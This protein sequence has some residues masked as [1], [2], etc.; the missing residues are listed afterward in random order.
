MHHLSTQLRENL[1]PILDGNQSTRH[2]NTIVNI[3]VSL[4]L[5][6]LERKRKGRQLTQSQGISET[7]L[8]Y[9]C[10]ADLF[11]RNDMGELV[12]I[13]AY[14][15]SVD[16]RAVDGDELLVQLRKLVYSRVNQAIFR[17]Y[18]DVDP[19]LSR[20]LRN[21]KL[22]VQRLCQFEIVDRFGDTFLVPAHCDSLQHLPPID[23]L[24]VE[25]HLLMTCDGTENV[26]AM[27]GEIEQY[28][29]QQEDHA[30][31]I[32]LI[33]TARI[34]RSTYEIK[35]KPLLTEGEILPSYDILD[36]TAIVKSACMLVKQEMHKS[37]VQKK[38]VSGVLFDAYF[39]A[40]LFSLTTRF[41][42]Q[43]GDNAGYF[44][45]LKQRLPQLTIDEYRSQHR[46]KLEYL[47][48]LANKRA[49]EAL[50][51]QIM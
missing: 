6:L 24:F 50:K 15:S 29:R 17:I 13:Q 22:A 41:T 21:I 42:D 8:A 23:E 7:D 47:G 38:K 26:P 18:Q 35:N 51:S 11:E 14:F 48:A 9:D 30:R 4:A 19:V 33:T 12:Q 2:L 20:I 34:I 40:I 10:V 32:G 25:Q 36:T 28:L 27:L 37:Y 31:F 49:T 45:A 46:A 39:E 16:V 3:C 1:P 5:E 43:D 44:E